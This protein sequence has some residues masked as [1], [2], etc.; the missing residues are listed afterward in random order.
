MLQQTEK[1]S[2]R[3]SSARRYTEARKEFPGHLVTLEVARLTQ[4]SRKLFPERIST[5]AGADRFWSSDR[6]RQI[7][8]CRPLSVEATGVGNSLA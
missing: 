8:R 2:A 3:E 7:R 4:Q 5:L 6:R 1:I